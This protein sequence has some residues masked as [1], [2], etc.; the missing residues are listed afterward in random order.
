MM[1]SI[2]QELSQGGME[3]SSRPMNAAINA[4]KLLKTN[5]PLAGV[6]LEPA[7][8]PITAM[9]LSSHVNQWYKIKW[10]P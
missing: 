9:N 2:N 5:A 10:T 3:I 1:I 8:F 7:N 4:M 6:S